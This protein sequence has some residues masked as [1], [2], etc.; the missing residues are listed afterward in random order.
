MRAI[1]KKKSNCRICLDAFHDMPF[2]ICLKCMADRTY[3]VEIIST[4][5]SF[6]GE[7]AIVKLGNSLKK[8]SLSELTIKEENNN[9]SN[10][11][12]DLA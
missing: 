7:Y 4:H 6:F 5:G 1:Y 2:D 3:E 11:Y 10:K 8:V 9:G 12:S